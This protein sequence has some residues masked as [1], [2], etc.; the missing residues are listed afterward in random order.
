[1]RSLLSVMEDQ[2]IGPT[3]RRYTRW[4]GRLQERDA[5]EHM[6]RSATQDHATAHAALEELLQ[7]PPAGQT[8]K[9]ERA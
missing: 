2:R 1:M 5:A 6:R 3:L 4:V 7:R 8:T 9:L